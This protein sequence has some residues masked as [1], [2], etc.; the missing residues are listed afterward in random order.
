MKI[1]G[2]NKTL[3][4]WV[5]VVMEEGKTF[6][7]LAEWYD[8]DSASVG[9]STGRCDISMQEVYAGDFIES[10]QGTQILDVLMLVKFGTYQAYCPVDQF[11]MDG[12]G[13]YVEAVGYP[14][15]PVGPLED[16][17]KVIGNTYENPEWLDNELEFNE[18][19]DLTN[20][21]IEKFAVGYPY[22]TD[23]VEILLK[24]YDYDTTK[25]HEILRKP[26]NE[27]IK[28]VQNTNEA[29]VGGLLSIMEA[30]Q[31]KSGF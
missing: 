7:G 5:Y 18:V 9:G 23:Y 15:M 3:N 16:Y 20:K 8:I 24:K 26:Y 31:R 6:E 28:E 1:R 29:P 19:N 2:F 10:H 30:R 12:V 11:Y 27:V 4:K 17:A 22:P 21:L 14:Q 13:F 25:V